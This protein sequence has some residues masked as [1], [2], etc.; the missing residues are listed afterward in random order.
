MKETA[1]KKEDCLVINNINR[2][3]KKEKNLYMLAIKNRVGTR[4]V[5]HTL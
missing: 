4:G 5:T 1:K 3:D 2:E